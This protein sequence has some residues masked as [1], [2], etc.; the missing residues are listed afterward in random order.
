MS[1]ML[2]VHIVVA[3]A[4][5]V[6]TLFTCLSPSVRKLTVS[7]GLTAAT[8][9]SGTYIVLSTHA[10]LTQACTTGLVYLGVMTAAVMAVRYRLARQIN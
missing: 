5:L 1:I 6:F 9:S 4:S 8:L 10:S 3:L 2:L 7:Y